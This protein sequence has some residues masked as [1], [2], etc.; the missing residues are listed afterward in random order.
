MEN[1]SKLN[2]QRAKARIAGM[3]RA[4]GDLA[5]ELGMPAGAKYAVLA[6]L[7]RYEQPNYRG[8]KGP[9]K[10]GSGKSKGSAS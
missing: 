3:D 7:F 10:Q 1:S 2:G 6:T 5:E 8:E 9:S 4:A